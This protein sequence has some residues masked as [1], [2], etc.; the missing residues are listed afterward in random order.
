[1]TELGKAEVPSA[2]APTSPPPWFP[3]AVGSESEPEVPLP[4]A[5]TCLYNFK[6]R[7]LA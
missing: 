4:S 7:P 2:P 6:T 5:I 1:M 3:S